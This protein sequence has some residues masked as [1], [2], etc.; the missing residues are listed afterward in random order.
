MLNAENQ[1]TKDLAEGG[2]LR[3]GASR[4]PSVCIAIFALTASLDSISDT[5]TITGFLLTLKISR[6]G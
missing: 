1:P 3:K 4:R 5:K 6:R 2:D